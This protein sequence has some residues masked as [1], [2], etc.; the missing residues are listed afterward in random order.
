[1]FAPYQVDYS[2]KNMS[3]TFGFSKK[4]I[5]FKFGVANPEALDQGLT[6]AHC[7]GSEH[8][9]IFIWSLNSG[10]RQIL[11]DGKDVHFSESGMN[12]WTSDQVFQHQFQMRIP[13]F[14][15]PVRCHLITQPAR[16]DDP[17]I[18][19]FDVRINGISFFR[20]SK[21]FQLGLPEMVSVPLNGG[22]RGGGGRYGSRSSIDPDNDPYCTP[23]ERKAIA[24]AKLASIREMKEREAR[25]GGGPPGGDSASVQS[26]PAAVDGNLIN[27]FDD[28]APPS[29][30][31][32]PF[33][34]PSTGGGMG[35]P[36]PSHF[37]SS[38]TM[39]ASFMGG[40]GGYQ[41]PPPPSPYG[42]GG[43][44]P[45]SNYSLS[46]PP[47]Q[48]A[49]PGQSPFQAAG[50]GQQPPLAQPNFGQPPAPVPASPYGQ[51]PAALQTYGQPSPVGYGQPPMD[52]FGQQQPPPPQTN[53]AAA[54]QQPPPAPQGYGQLPPQQNPYDFAAAPP[55]GGSVGGGS[56]N[57]GM[58]M[59]SPTAQSVASYG[60]APSFAQPPRPAIPQ[61]QYQ[62]FAQF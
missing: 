36:V 20:F 47:P 49:V 8:E 52:P 48:P 51:P 44:Q 15:V 5:S 14:S 13:N 1:M 34:P 4:A 23:E 28:P 32:L 9:I 27:L 19:P 6:G 41:A 60:S 53:Y 37:V 7:R 56:M 30:Q 59:M 43:Q 50:Y 62:S 18:K 35:A 21:I 61:P 57:G 11:A 22:S 33:L 54:Y 40:G 29:Q 25:G 16:A 42:G 46:S 26:A 2:V 38:M 3:K 17:Q 45:Y 58:M 55:P 24:A 31:S 12:G 10:K 39:D